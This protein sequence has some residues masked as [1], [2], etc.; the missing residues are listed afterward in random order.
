MDWCTNIQQTSIG[1]QI[2]VFFCLSHFLFRVRFARSN[3]SRRAFASFVIGRVAKEY[4]HGKMHLLLYYI[5]RVWLFVAYTVLH[6]IP[7]N[8]I[9]ESNKTTAI[10]KHAASNLLKLAARTKITL[11][12]EWNEEEKRNKRKYIAY[13]Y[14]KWHECRNAC[15]SVYYYIIYYCRYMVV[16]G[17]GS[18]A[19]VAVV[20]VLNFVF[21]PFIGCCFFIVYFVFICLCT[22]FFWAVFFLSSFL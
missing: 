10:K 8:H 18:A 6:V 3:E 2:V 20:V 14:M 17:T 13:V 21:E 15:I 22:G 12:T 7:R 9:C 1:M 4:F 16:C 11:K 5:G 19:A